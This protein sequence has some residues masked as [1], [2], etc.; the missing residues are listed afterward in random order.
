MLPVVKGGHD[1]VGFRK[2]VELHP[3]VDQSEG[4][5]VIG[6][7]IQIRGVTEGVAHLLERLPLAVLD[8]D[9]AELSAVLLGLRLVLGGGHASPTCSEHGLPVV[10]AHSVRR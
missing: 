6:A 1:I 8:Y 5:L 10:P 2:P 3:L 9:A 4:P 7:R